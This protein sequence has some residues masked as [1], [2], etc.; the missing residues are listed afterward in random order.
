MQDRGW[1]EV[2]GEPGQFIDP[3]ALNRF[4]DLQIDQP[5][6]RDGA[7][8]P[9]DMRRIQLEELY[10]ATA[11]PMQLAQQRPYMSFI[12]KFARPEDGLCIAKVVLGRVPLSHDPHVIEQRTMYPLDTRE[13]RVEFR[14]FALIFDRDGQTEPAFEPD[15]VVEDVFPYLPFRIDIRHLRELGTDF[16][17]AVAGLDDSRNLL[18]Q[19]AFMLDL[20][21]VEDRRTVGFQHVLHRNIAC[22]IVKTRWHPKLRF[23]VG[24]WGKAGRAYHLDVRIPTIAFLSASIPPSW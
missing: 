8:R 1:L 7:I 15:P 22:A 17:D 4:E 12:V 2:D 3:A 24:V 19:L 20:A 6:N 5:P 13:D 16:H 10:L 14:F 11:L 21:I 9:F 18:L 23:N